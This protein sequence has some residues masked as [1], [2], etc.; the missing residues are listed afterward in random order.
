MARPVMNTWQ[1][2][3]E[4]RDASCVPL[5]QQLAQ[6]FID[7]IS[8]G[9]LTPNTRLPSSRKLAASLN[10]HRNTILAAYNELAVQGWITTTRAKGTFVSKD[11]PITRPRSFAAGRRSVAVQRGG[12]GYALGKLVIP[13][14][15]SGPEGGLPMGGERLIRA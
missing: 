9:R 2:T 8:R 6:A 10:L 5:Y 12:A 14:R 11:I 7:D 15:L 4:L 1:V 3:V 13:G